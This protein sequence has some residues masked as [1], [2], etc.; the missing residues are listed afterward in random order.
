MI[1]SD[2]EKKSLSLAKAVVYRLFKFR[3]RSEKEIIAK[4]KDKDFDSAIIEQVVS[5]F[6]KCGLINDAI[7]AKGWISSR[8]NKP[9]GFKRIRLELRDKGVADEIISAEFAK[10]KTNYNEL[11][12]VTK[13]AQRRIKIYH[14]IDRATTRRRLEGYLLRRGFAPEVIYKVLKAGMRQ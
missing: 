13:I 7:F 8:L 11:E 14:G 4:L 12:S 6:V 3:P 10:I 2:D 1:P 5:F 9:M